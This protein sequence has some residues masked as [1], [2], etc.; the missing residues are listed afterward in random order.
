MNGET[1]RTSLTHHEY[2]QN[3]T[4]L[5]YLGHHKKFMNPFVLNNL[6]LHDNLL[7]LIAL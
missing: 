2:G 1:C 4:P 3:H 7:S 5:F 6:L